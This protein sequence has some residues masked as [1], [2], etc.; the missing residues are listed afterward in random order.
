M[1]FLWCFALY[2]SLVE[3]TLCSL[4]KLCMVTTVVDLS[5]SLMLVF[6]ME[7]HTWCSTLHYAYSVKAR[8]SLAAALYKTFP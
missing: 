1:Q 7:V 5:L 3:S 2:T 6:S 4:V 8:L